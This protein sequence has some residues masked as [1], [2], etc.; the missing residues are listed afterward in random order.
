MSLRFTPAQAQAFIK[1]FDFSLSSP[2]SGKTSGIDRYE[3]ILFRSCTT[4]FDPERD[5]GTFLVDLR[6]TAVFHLYDSNSDNRLEINELKELIRDMCASD[7]HIQWVF[8]KLGISSQTQCSLEFFKSAP[9]LT[10]FNSL[11]LK[12]RYLLRS[13]HNLISEGVQHHAYP[14]RVQ[15]RTRALE[16]V[17]DSLD[18]GLK[19]GV[20]PCAS[21]P[22]K[23]EAVNP[24]IE[25]EPGIISEV[26]MRG[27]LV[28]RSSEAFAIATAVIERC[29]QLSLATY[30]ESDIGDPSWLRSG[31]CLAKMLNCKPDNFS[32]IAKVVE[33]LSRFEKLVNRNCNLKM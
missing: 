14:P 19:P 33:L 30:N 15:W 11:G 27:L 26:D 21:A 20:I 8:E 17:G 13:A 3:Y 6:L 4:H 29:R 18:D 22:I 9:C 7:T 5:N 2:L 28:N 24:G 10:L 32:E 31:A 1:T 23:T 25:L 12:T 16:A